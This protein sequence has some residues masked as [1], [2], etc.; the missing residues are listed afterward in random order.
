MCAGGN[1]LAMYKFDMA[2]PATEAGTPASPGGVENPTLIWAKRM[3]DETTNPA[4]TTGHSGSFTYDGKLLVYGHEPG[5]G[6]GASCEASDSILFRS[7]YFLDPETGADRGSFVQPR[8]QSSTENCT[9]HNFNVV[10]T[11]KGYY[12]VSGNYEMGISVFDFSNPQA[13]EQ[14][15]FADPAE[16]STSLAPDRRQ[17]VDALLQ[18]PH[19][20]V[21][22]PPRR[23]HLE[24]RPRRDAPR[25]PG[26]PVQ[27]A[28][29]DDVVRAGPRGRVDHDRPARRGRAVQAGRRADGQLL[30]HGL[31]LRRRVVRRPGGQRRRAGH[32]QDRRARVQGHGGRQGRQRHD[33]DASPTWSTAPT[34][35]AA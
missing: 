17:L 13:T 10:P 35:P 21:R 25:A 5:G 33:Q 31:R 19:L 15:A 30:V 3:P 24:P 22:H 28:D 9:W 6:T 4:V 23:A 14:I 16:Y 8:P 7:L 34:S 32:E 26:R 2:K 29:P 18:R 27:P 11:Y 12:G 1:G 20:R